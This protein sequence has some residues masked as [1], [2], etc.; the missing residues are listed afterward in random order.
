ML[1][2]ILE[3]FLSIISLG[4]DLSKELSGGKNLA[5]IN[6]LF[7]LQ[8]LQLKT[9]KSLRRNLEVSTPAMALIIT[10]LPPDRF[11]FRYKEIQYCL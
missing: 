8:R 7:R 2:I 10:N 5:N 6:Q 11:R 1:K 9:K 3:S 4:L